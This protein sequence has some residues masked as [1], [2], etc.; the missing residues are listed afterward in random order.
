MTAFHGS[1]N[2]QR[3]SRPQPPIIPKL[4]VGAWNLTFFLNVGCW[5]L[6]LLEGSPG[7]RASFA[8][9]LCQGA[10]SGQRTQR[11]LL[12]AKTIKPKPNST[13]EEGSGTGAR[14]KNAPS[15]MLRTGSPLS[16][17]PPENVVV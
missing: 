15:P 10:I 6:E 7:S 4:K 12:A 13:I 16:Q 5:S 14:V 3:R 9:S 1:S 11:H 2:I 8:H 17:E